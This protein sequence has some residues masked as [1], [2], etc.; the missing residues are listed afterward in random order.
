MTTNLKK[1]AEIIGLE[2]M[3]AMSGPTPSAWRGQIAEAL[4]DAGLLADD[5]NY[6]A[7][8]TEYRYAVARD[9]NDTIIISDNDARV[10]IRIP[11]EHVSDMII[12]LIAAQKDNTDD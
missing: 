1:A 12:A 9:N 8:G 5:D 3:D 10:T 6:L 2:Y 4:D 11:G 7:I